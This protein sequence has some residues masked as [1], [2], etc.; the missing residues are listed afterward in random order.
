MYSHTLQV[1]KSSYI[2]EYEISPKKGINIEEE[3]YEEMEY[4]TQ[5]TQQKNDN[6]THCARPKPKKRRSLGKR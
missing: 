1:G 4:G 3:M 6:L 2:A 5:H